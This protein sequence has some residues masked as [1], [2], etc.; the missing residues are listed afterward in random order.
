[1]ITILWET[2]RDPCIVNVEN[3]VQFTVN[4]ASCMTQNKNIYSDTR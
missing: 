1:M 2:E 4:A 3:V